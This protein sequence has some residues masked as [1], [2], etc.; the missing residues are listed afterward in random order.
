MVDPS[1]SI[2]SVEAEK[3]SASPLLL[4]R[5]RISN[6]QPGRIENILLA[7]QIRIEPTLRAYSA[8]E[9]ERL[10][11]LF[12][13]PERWSQTVHSLLWTHANVAVPGFEGETEAL[14]PAQ[15][16]HDFN[17]ASAK[18]FYGLKDGDVP[19]SFLFCGSIFHKDADGALQIA[20]IPWSKEARFGL[21]SSVW[22][23]LMNA[24]YPDCE[25]LRLGSQTFD[26]LYEFK[27]RRGLLT[28]DDALNEL[29]QN[30]E[31]ESR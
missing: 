17:V 20:Q 9:R 6:K 3:F 12:G 25:L 28:F 14:L 8:R 4:F 1:F 18:Y 27:R 19:L 22:R 23:D 30:V 7:C 29:L 26:R 5:L 13:V 21:S 16:T 11:E 31:V 10:G 15:C 24:Y 2:E